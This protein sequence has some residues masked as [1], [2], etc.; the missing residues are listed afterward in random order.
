M[1]MLSDEL[2]AS[3][4]ASIQDVSR[5]AT[6]P[7]AL[8]TSPEVLAVEAETMFMKE[9]LCVGR[10]ERIAHV[11]DWFTVTIVDEPIIVARNKNGDICAM[12][13]DCGLPS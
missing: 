7:A 1:T 6:L 13:A 12:S 10:A 8:Y 11:G 3:L 2:L 9:W 4:D 5:A